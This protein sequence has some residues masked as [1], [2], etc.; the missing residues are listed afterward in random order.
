MNKR[1]ELRYIQF[2][3]DLRRYCSRANRTSNEVPDFEEEK[4]LTKL[5]RIY[6]RPTLRLQ[7]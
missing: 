6:C 4:G 5:H 1:L 3:V 2:S 7:P